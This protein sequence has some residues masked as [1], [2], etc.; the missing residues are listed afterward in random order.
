[1]TNSTLSI[2]HSTFLDAHVH[3]WKYDAENPE[4]DWIDSTMS[5]I[6]K[7]FLPENLIQNSKSNIQNFIAVQASQT[8]QETEF[9]LDLAS[10]HAFIKGVVG[11]I[12]LVQSEEFIVRSIQNFNYEPSTINYKLLKGFRHILQAEPK[13]FMLQSRFIE[14][15]KT[16]GKLGYTYDILIKYTQ[17]DE[18]F[19]LVK[20][21][22][23]QKFVID[24]LAKP[25]IKNRE[26]ELWKKG[27]SKFA[28]VDN[29]Y[30]KVS[31]MVTEADWGNWKKEDFN[32]YLDTVFNVFGTDRIMFGSDWPVCLL[33]GGYEQA[34]NIV[35]EYISTLSENEKQKIMATNA[36][37][38]YN[39]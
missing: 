32:P 11:W 38:F 31:G 12:D 34:L 17:L 8:W 3:F 33:A 4:F 21:S 6:S 14:G 20:Q 7:T 39:I 22:P 37:T 26:I 18:A 16:I 10:K 28:T 27:I 36:A 15:I 5:K 9:L 25:D 30:C 1:M 19:E 24:H 13:G 23:N 2:Q 29:V 35:E